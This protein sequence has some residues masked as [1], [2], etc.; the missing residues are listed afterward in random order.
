M[1]M[2]ATEL[3]G[4]VLIRAR[5]TVGRSPERVG[6]QVGVSGRT[7]RRLEEGTST[8]PRRTTLQVLAGYYGLNPEFLVTLTTWSA[9]REHGPDV[10]SRL[11]ERAVR[12][13]GLEVAESLLADADGERE[14]A[15]RLARAPQATLLSSAVPGSGR[16]WTAT[17]LLQA[18]GGLGGQGTNDRDRIELLSAV[19]GLVSLD[20]R[21]RRLV[22]ELIE[23]LG[24]VQAAD[25]ERRPFASGGR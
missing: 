14:L 12:E 5:A 16:A 15:M 9:Q 1:S 11:N 18:L 8:R 20:R 19:G 2:T 21:R 7:I 6:E 10:R 24:D 3:L 4:D 23:Q 17:A 22:A 25:L 13:L